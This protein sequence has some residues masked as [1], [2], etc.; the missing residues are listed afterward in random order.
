LALYGKVDEIL[1]DMEFGVRFWIGMVT[2]EDMRSKLMQA[3]V[4]VLGNAASVDGARLDYATVIGIR[5]PPCL[6]YRL[7]AVQRLGAGRRAA[8][9]RRRKPSKATHSAAA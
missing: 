7:T 1:M 2:I 3:L 5:L 4:S 6:L 8:S 9:P